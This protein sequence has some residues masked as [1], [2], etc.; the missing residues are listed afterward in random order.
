MKYDVVRLN[1]NS[2]LGVIMIK[3]KIIE[4]NGI[5]FY[6]CLNNVWLEDDTHVILCDEEFDVIGEIED[7]IND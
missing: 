7:D 1:K 6:N 4:I 2:K 5:Q 3:S